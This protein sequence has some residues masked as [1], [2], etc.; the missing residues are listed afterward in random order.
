MDNAI[1]QLEKN[2]G[3]EALGHHNIPVPCGT[4]ECL[5]PL[6]TEE[7]LVCQNDKI[8][9]LSL[10]MG[11]PSKAMA[12]FF[13][14]VEMRWLLPDQAD[15]RGRGLFDE[16]LFSTRLHQCHFPMCPGPVW[17]GLFLARMDYQFLIEVLSNAQ[18]RLSREK[19]N[20]GCLL[21]LLW[22]VG[23]IWVKESEGERANQLVFL[24]L[25]VA[26]EADVPRS[27]GFHQR[28][29]KKTFPLI[30]LSFVFF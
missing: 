20:G 30:R 21:F 25:K 28:S 5:L 3:E 4:L 19:W 18:S 22:P 8:W 16:D 23:F 9:H 17:F 2:P 11:S 14:L 10:S 13:R 27:S 24:Q 29:I 7:P 12:S 15:Q 6:W 1:P 26:S